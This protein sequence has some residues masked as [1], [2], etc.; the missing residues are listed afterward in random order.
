MFPNFT[1]SFPGR[2]RELGCGPRWRL[3]AVPAEGGVPG[4]APPPWVAGPW[5]GAHPPV[6]GVF[7]QPFPGHPHGSP[8]DPFPALPA[9]GAAPSL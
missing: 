7:L 6:P 2:E 8:G 4:P 5:L 1:G 9:P 3:R